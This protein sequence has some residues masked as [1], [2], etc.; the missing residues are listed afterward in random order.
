MSST[1]MWE[2]L[3]RNKKDLPNEMKYILRKKYG[4]PV[5]IVLSERDIEYLQGVK[6]AGV[7]SIETLINAIEKYQEI[8]VQEE[9]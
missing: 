5:K 9:W 8:L 4:E 6:D 3:R 2:P 7:E 1:L